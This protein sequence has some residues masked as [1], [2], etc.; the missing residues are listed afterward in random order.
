MGIEEFDKNDWDHMHDCVLDATWDTVKKKSTREELIEIFNT[1]PT[2]LQ[3]E[4]YEFG[5]ND[6]LWREDF[7]EWYKQSELNNII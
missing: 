5:M 2:H 3:A 1:L 4:A 6:T 7:I